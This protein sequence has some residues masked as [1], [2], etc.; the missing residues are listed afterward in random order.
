MGICCFF[1]WGTCWQAGTCWSWQA[2]LYG[3]R[4]RNSPKNP[5][6][7][8]GHRPTLH[9]H[10]SGH[11]DQW[12]PRDTSCIS[13]ISCSCA[14][15]RSLYIQT[16]PE[17]VFWPQNHTLNTFSEGIWMSRGLEILSCFFPFVW[18]EVW[19]SV[20]EFLRQFKESW[21][22]MSQ[23]IAA[24]SNPNRKVVGRLFANNIQAIIG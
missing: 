23:F 2:G 14:S 12:K 13:N 7:D 4:F 1:W 17:K 19:D 11:L 3:R 21:F 5:M 20:V 6:K 15:F 9:L 16:P 18:G 24:K 22:D 8:H 10:F